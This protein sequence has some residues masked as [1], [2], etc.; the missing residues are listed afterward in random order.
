MGR[1]VGIGMHDAI[2]IGSGPNG[3]AAA[4]E[5][6]RNGRSV[7]V[8]EGA[9]TV[10]GSCR[11]AEL[12]LPG[13]V[14]DI[15]STVAALAISSPLIRSLPLEQLGVQLVQPP[16]AFAHPLDDGTAAVLE[17][18]I[19]ATGETLGL[20]AQAWSNLMRP[21]VEHWGQLAPTLLSPPRFPAHPVLM[22]RFG[23][24][25][26]RSAQSLALSRFD[27]PQARALFAGVAAHAI[28]PLD[29][30]ATA[31]FGLVLA[32][33]AH[34]DGWPISRGGMQNL[35]NAMATHLRSLGGEI[36]TDAP[37]RSLDELP[38]ARAI[39][40]DVSPRQLLQLAGDR[41]PSN[42]KKKLE[43]F[44]Y[45]P[46][47]FKIDWALAGPIPWKASGC[48]RAATVHLGG[49]IEEIAAS[50]SAPWRGEHC[51][52]PYV[53]LVQP[54]LFDPTRAP[55]GKH[56]AWAYCH[57]PNGSTKDM[58]AAIESQVERFA[59]GFRDLILARSTM[60]CV[61]LERRNPNLIGGDIT[62]GANTLSQLFTRPVASFNPY[63]TPVPN[64]YL[65]SA[66]TPPG[67]GVHGMCGFNAARAVLRGR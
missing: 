57:V 27:R 62:G 13:Y 22:A 19:Q 42:Y 26:M 50:E 40:C 21:L 39:L 60:N 59:L 58:T 48:S 30:K 17:R 23:L 20:D 37:V 10:G 31:S 32:A 6:A 47:A 15:C 46:G 56:T 24:L 45:G 1:S 14:H 34:A 49:T 3:L 67:G 16:A 36:I 44:R 25:A 2:I 54:S 64:L 33:S 29:W 63:R 11:S 12:T 28:L 4:I 18:S 53:L 66:S 51:E 7:L 55:P 65:C 38:P 9:A 52:K 41:L 5:L 8:R 61:D 43:R 35:A